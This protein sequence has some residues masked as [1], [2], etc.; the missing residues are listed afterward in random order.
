MENTDTNLITTIRKKYNLLLFGVLTSIPLFLWVL[1]M[2]FDYSEGII[3]SD[4]E[5]LGFE[6]FV[7]FVFPLIVA[8]IISGLT[9]L[10]AK[11][12]SIP[13][14]RWIV[15]VGLGVIIPLIAFL[16]VFIAHFITRK[17]YIGNK[18]YLPGILSMMTNI[19]ENQELRASEDPSAKLAKLKEMLDKGLI[20]RR[21]Y[22]TKKDHILSKM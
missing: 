9:L 18:E 5:K 20:S 2:I 16:L 21:D 12:I 17:I 10:I 19:N 15:I 3:F 11:L 8:P 4:P 7:A 6:L 22:E 13:V 14:I 1:I